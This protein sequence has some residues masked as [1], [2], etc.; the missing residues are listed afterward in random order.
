VLLL[1][2]TLAGGLLLAALVSR[3][4]GPWDHTVTGMVR[5]LAGTSAGVE[6]MAAAVTYG[7]VRAGVLRAWWFAVPALMLL[8][9]LLRVIFAPVP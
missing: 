6:V 8:T 4:E 9:A 5:V 3:S 7:C 2:H 1:F